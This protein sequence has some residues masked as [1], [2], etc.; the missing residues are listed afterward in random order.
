[1]AKI[2]TNFNTGLSVDAYIFSLRTG[3]VYN[4]V[5]QLMETYTTG[6]VGD[7][8]TALTEQGQSQIYISNIPAA[9]PRDLY[10][11]VYK[12]RLGDSPAE[13]DAVIRAS[14]SIDFTGFTI[15]ALGDVVDGTGSVTIDILGALA[16]IL[17]TINGPIQPEYNTPSAAQLTT[18]ICNNAGDVIATIVTD[19]T[20]STFS[21]ISATGRL[22][23]SINSEYLPE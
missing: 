20:D 21:R 16:I 5:S 12:N 15:R 11:L 18:D 19:F 10:V 23:A 7:Y 3:K 9:L 14:D 8:V 4:T 22:V 1:M 17:S 6:D 2:I 13:S